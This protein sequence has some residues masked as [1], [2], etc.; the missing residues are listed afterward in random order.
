M[1][2][3][4]E[5]LAAIRQRAEAAT[6]G[7]WHQRAIAILIRYARKQDGAWNDDE[8]YAPEQGILPY[9]EE[10]D[11]AFISSARMDVPKLCDLLEAYNEALVNLSKQFKTVAKDVDGCDCEECLEH[12]PIN[13]PPC[14]HERCG[15]GIIEAA[16]ARIT[17]LLQPARKDA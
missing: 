10:E 6:P 8:L 11:A 14:H 5:S 2:T 9:H 3:L 13:E 16:Y 17:T 7:P 1:N 15:R 4:K 12:W